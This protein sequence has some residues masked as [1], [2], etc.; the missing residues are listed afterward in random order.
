MYIKRIRND[1]FI[2]F[3][4]KGHYLYNNIKLK[5]KII[6]ELD[7]IEKRKKRKENNYEYG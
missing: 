1:I 6:N 3:R 5:W 4:Q 7:I 2:A